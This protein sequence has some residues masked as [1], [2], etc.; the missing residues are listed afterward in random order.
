MEVTH[1][2]SAGHV[3]LPKNSRVARQWK[4]GQELIAID[5][6]DGILLKPKNPFPATTLEQVAGCLK[7]QGTPK[8]W[9]R[10]KLK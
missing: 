1:L 7:Y 8:N 6:G 10:W 4:A 5:V 9:K 3:I 2:S